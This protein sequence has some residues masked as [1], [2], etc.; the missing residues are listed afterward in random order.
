L[1]KEAFQMPA[2]F[3][4]QSVIPTVAIKDRTERF[5]VHR[6]YCIGRNY[7]EHAKEMGASAERGVRPVVFMKPNDAVCENGVD[8]AF[9][10]ATQNLHFEAE[11]VVALQSGG[12]DI[13][14]E[15]AL[16]HVFGYAIGNDLTKRDLQ[17]EAKKAGLPWDISK[18]FDHSAPIGPIT[19][20]DVCGH[21]HEGAIELWQNGL[22]KQSADL[23]EM[24]W[25]VPEIINELSKLF[26]LQAG[27]LIFTGT[28]A[29][30]G[31]I[32]RGDRID[33]SIAGLGRL[34]NRI[35]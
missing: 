32:A 21:I 24:L 1:K 9:P 19:P 13:P 20:A 11:L 33:I 35:V 23:S 27:D 29:G 26:L 22:I 3:I 14:V 30:V 31:A 18:G 6:I 15:H 28:P 4:F 8:I 12:K 10:S 7:A 25:S 2:T 34:A 16:S 17:L 5:P